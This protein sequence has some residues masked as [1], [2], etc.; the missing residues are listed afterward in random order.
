MKR[1][2]IIELIGSSLTVLSLGALVWIMLA[3]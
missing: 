2:D 1:E 3:L